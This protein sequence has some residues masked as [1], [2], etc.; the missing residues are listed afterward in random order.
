MET[1]T[2]P[3][4]LTPLKREKLSDSVV[5]IIQEYIVDNGLVP[6]DKLPSE[7]EFAAALNVG[8]R[9]IREALR[10]LE[11]RGMARI[12]HGKGTF[13]DEKYRDDYA[14]FL[15]DSLRLDSPRDQQLL[16]DLIYVR[17]I[18][19]TSVIADFAAHP[20]KEHLDRLS[21]IMRKLEKAEQANDVE[22]YN[23]WDITFHKTIIASTGNQILI[24]LYDRLSDLFARSFARTA[25]LPGG[26][27]RSL[28]E[29]TQLLDHVK[30]GDVAKARE[31]LTVHLEHTRESLHARSQGAAQAVEG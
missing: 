8:T 11:A 28:G 9:S 22:A 4:A 1:T 15:A 7:R 5:R 23:R 2:A 6:G 12:V 30:A 3:P 19:E 17:T 26:M 16:I 25:S 13:V 27:Q 24:N 29:H 21:E 20:R 31:L 18:I 10:H 14:R